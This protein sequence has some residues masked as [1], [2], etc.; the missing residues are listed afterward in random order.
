ME[1]EDE[2]IVAIAVVCHEAIRAWCTAH[3]DPSQPAWEDA[4][5]WQRDSAVEAVDFHIDHPD[6]GD[7]AT[8]DA[9][10]AAKERDGWVFGAVKDAEAKTHPCLVPFDQLPVFQQKKDAL[11]RAIVHALK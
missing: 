7:S 10:M 8:H 5:E 1:D 6:A 2:K 9:W 11:V 3:D 4:P